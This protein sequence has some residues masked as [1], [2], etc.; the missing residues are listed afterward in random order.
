MSQVL[1]H[2]IEAEKMAIDAVASH[3]QSIEVLML[4]CCQLQKSQFLLSLDKENNYV[5]CR[6]N[7]NTYIDVIW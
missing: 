5:L 7:I 4:F 1:G 6:Q 2:N 3:G